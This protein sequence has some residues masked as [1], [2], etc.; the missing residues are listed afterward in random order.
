ML[1]MRPPKTTRL[2]IKD[3]EIENC[4]SK[5]KFTPTEVCTGTQH[6]QR[7]RQSVSPYISDMTDPAS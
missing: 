2:I 4:L 1:E 5:A 7:G 3:I 6:A